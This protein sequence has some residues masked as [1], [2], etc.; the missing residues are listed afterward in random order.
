MLFFPERFLQYFVN[1]YIVQT[2]FETIFISFHSSK[3]SH[4][5]N[6]CPISSLRNSHKCEKQVG[7]I[8]LKYW[9]NQPL[10]AYSFCFVIPYINLTNFSLDPRGL[11]GQIYVGDQ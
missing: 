10:N 4:V 9:D 7:C 3:L 11:I 1:H 2:Q 6:K 5:Q 8:Y